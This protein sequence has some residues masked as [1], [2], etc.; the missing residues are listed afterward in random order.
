VATAPTSPSVPQH[1]SNASHIRTYAKDLAALGGKAAKLSATRPTLPP[2]QKI[3][4]AAPAASEPAPA[5]EKQAS[6]PPPPPAYIIPKAAST[7]ETRED[8]L[9]R[10]RGNVEA[11]QNAAAPRSVAK[12]IPQQ[13]SRSIPSPP[14]A[15][16]IPKAPSTNESR[17][18][19]L[20]RLQ[21][22]AAPIV[23]ST[24]QKPTPAPEPIHTFKTDFAQRIDTQGASTFAVLAAQ[25]DSTQGGTARIVEKK[26]FP[27][28]I[29]AGI[30]LVI[31]G[32]SGV[33]AAYLF[34]QKPVVAVPTA[35]SVPSLIL[36]SDQTKLEG[37]G[38]ALVSSLVETIL[39]PSSGTT[40]IVY[41]TAATT[42]AE[43]VATD[44]PLGGDALFAAFGFPVPDILLRSIEPEST[45]GTFNTGNGPMPFFILRVSSF[46]RSFAGMLDWEP[47]MSRDLAA[48][49]ARYPSPLPEV[50]ATTT[51]TTTAP[52]ATSTPTVDQS[53]P[54]AAFVDEVIQ[55]HDVR[56][57]KDL[58]G[59]SLILYGYAD[60]Q[61]L[62]IARDENAFRLLLQALST[63]H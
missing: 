24:P 35:V 32:V 58:A 20:A 23:S 8:V 19:I 40:R 41:I 46:E 61:T 10:L 42:T 18:A 31:L 25:Q 14:P 57:L 56:V 49:Y 9:A 62:I 11:T 37:R 39:L 33:T 4:V 13:A 28:A 53:A 43:G 26:S 6:I 34:V 29:I 48:L 17:E 55:N 22:N 45:I 16:V 59:R 54:A 1:D 36:A 15:R 21:R 44:V 12:E 38:A 60:K 5:Q 63:A 52:A 50:T 51:A 27:F 30:I 47:T 2:K 3:A 7:T